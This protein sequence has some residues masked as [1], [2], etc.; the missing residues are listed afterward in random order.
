DDKKLS[1]NNM[2]KLGFPSL[3]TTI[4]QIPIDEAARI[5]CEVIK[6]FLNSHKND[7]DFQLI[8]IDQD[9]RVLN[10]FELEWE[11]FRDNEE[12]RFQMKLGDFVEIMIETEI[13]YDLKFLSYFTWLKPGVTPLGKSLYDVIGSKLFEE[14]KRL[15]PDPGV[16]GEAYPVPIP[17]ASEF[18]QGVKQ[19]IYVISPNMNPSRSDPVSLDVAKNALKESYQSMLNAFWTLKNGQ[20]YTPRGQ[21]SQEK[22]SA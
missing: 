7:L 1:D 22:R 11:K 4:G 15:Y 8:L 3:S 16:V 9:D 12:S 14:I 19:I 6:E 13:E 10:A 2:I 5:A 21:Q 18:Y 20:Q 17:S